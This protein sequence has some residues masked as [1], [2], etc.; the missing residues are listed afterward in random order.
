MNRR[1]ALLAACLLVFSFAALAEDA[2][3]SFTVTKPNGKPLHNASI[4][5]HPVDKHGRQ[6]NKG[7]ELKSNREGKAS[8]AGVPYGRLRIQVIAPGYQTYGQDFVINQL[9]QEIAIKMEKPKEQ[10]SIYK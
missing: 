1:I 2:T 7:L 10:Y 5:L 9:D 3:L 4:I 8:Y 6:S